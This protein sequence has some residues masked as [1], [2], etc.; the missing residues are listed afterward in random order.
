MAQMALILSCGALI[1]VTLTASVAYRFIR[2]YRL[3]GDDFIGE[4]FGADTGLK[5]LNDLEKGL[6]KKKAQ[7]TYPFMDELHSALKAR[8]ERLRKLRDEEECECEDDDLLAAIYNSF[9]FILAGA[10]YQEVTPSSSFS[11]DF[12]EEEDDS[13]AMSVDVHSE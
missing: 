8:Q 6:G 5:D 12:G 1:I 9:S 7:H 4:P 3:N 13:D 10:S 2:V 11:L